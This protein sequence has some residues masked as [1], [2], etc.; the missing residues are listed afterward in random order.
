M[1]KSWGFTRRGDFLAEG[2]VVAAGSDPKHTRGFG[3]GQTGEAVGA[4]GHYPGQHPE[5]YPEHRPEHS[6]RTEQGAYKGAR[7]LRG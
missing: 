3:P 6:D 4:L 5:H 7:A 1:A 2:C